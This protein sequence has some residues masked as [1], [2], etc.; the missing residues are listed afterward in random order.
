MNLKRLFVAVALICLIGSAAWGAVTGSITGIVTDEQTNEPLVGVSVSV[1][2]TNL[3]GLTDENGRYRIINVPVD[4]Y[5]LRFTTVGYAPV[6]VQN[7]SVSV[8]L[9]TY[10][11]VS[12]TSEAAD[13]EQTIQVTAERPLV[14]KDKTTTMDVVSKEEILALPTRGFDAVVGIQNSVVRN[15]S[16]V[17][18]RQRGGRE[19]L[20]QGA[21]LNIRG[22]RPSEVAYYVD[23]FSQQ[24]PLSGISTANINNN[25]IQEVS[26]QSGAFSAEYG[27][28]ASGVVNVTTASGANQFSGNV[29][30]VS[31]QPTTAFGYDAF[32]HNWYSADLSGPIPGLDRSYFFISGERRYFGDREPSIVTKDVYEAFGLAGNFGEPQRLPSN[33][34]DGWSFQGKLD[35]N[36]TPNFK[37]QFSG[38]GSVDKWQEYRHYFLNPAIIEQI[39][40]APLYEDINYGVNA[41]ITHTLSAE[42]FYNMSVSYFNTERF[43]GDGVL[44]DDLEAY[45]R[46]SGFPN[47]EYDFFNL[48]RQPD[49]V[50]AS[51]VDT[52]I[53]PGSAEDTLVGFD[54]SFWQNYLDR[55]SSYIGVKGDLNSQIS[56]A[57]TVKLGFDFQYHTV[58]YYENLDATDDIAPRILNRYG[59]D[60][61]GEVDDDGGRTGELVDF[62]DVKNPINLG[63]YLQDRLE[64]QGL[65]VN[66]GVRF[67][68]FD[69]KAIRLSNPEQPFGADNSTLDID[70]DLED[71]EKFT[72]VS[73]RLG[74]SFPVS[75]RTQMHINYGIFYQRPDL[76]RLYLG[77][78]FLE[79]RVTAGSFYPFP[80]PN[81]EPETIT[82]YEVGVTQQLGEN[83]A[84]GITAYYKDVKDLT[85][86]F[87]QS[88]VP[89]AY[90]FYDNTD[91]G[92]IKGVDFNLNMRRT[93]NIAVDV[94]YTL[95]WA[96]GTGSYANS[97]FNVA[98][99]NPQGEPKVT[100]PLDYDQ[101][102]N[103]IGIFDLRTGRGEGPVVGGTHILENLGLNAVVQ[104][105]SGTPYTPMQVYDGVTINAAVTQQPTGPINS[106]RLPWTFNVD[107]KLER[108]F[109][110]GDYR[111]T[112][113]VWVR[114]LLDRENIYGVYEG[115]GEANTS[116]YLNSEEGQVR[117]SDPD[118]GEEF[119]YRYDLGQNNP[120]NYGIPRMIYLGLRMSF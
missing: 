10:Q 52:N 116:G 22:G 46:G 114:N 103:I 32:D 82:Q 50:F 75:D 106:A 35:F 109:E 13:L 42:T 111:F 71:S 45:N 94:K 58:R 14:M 72:R 20:A 51:Q 88:A 3:G 1:L 62:N 118:T 38:N 8:D 115:T 77:Y 26:I 60:E 53:A 44:F 117:A 57:N 56:A 28:V 110:V 23:G 5:V 6:E 11:N 18:I 33:S 61:N 101:R 4:N 65:I 43:R 68:Y 104:L 49:S 25:A 108:A 80:S 54:F 107:L 105:A 15:F 91:F 74:I 67:D 47:P 55:R 95:S 92:T 40:H 12:L 73:P 87:H 9:T 112:P 113:Y 31:D 24:D 27:H 119:A 21:E 16:N 37:L 30:V 99:K 41:K 36:L 89:T 7:V 64:W 102:H 2:G 84:L 97:Q 39:R 48:F 120:K 76:R 69:Y 19:S 83:T 78:D 34:L 85:Q 66:A 59:F 17:D 90:D 79:A 100:N 96:E 93:R 81:L 63:I 98:W 70:E 86:I 29:E